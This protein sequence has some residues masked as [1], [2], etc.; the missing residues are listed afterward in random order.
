MP[1]GKEDAMSV[2]KV[3]ELLAES[4]KSWEDAA[5]DAVTEASKTIE[6]IQSVYVEN[7]QAIVEGAKIVKY[8]VNVKVCFLVKR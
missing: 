3:I 2:V 1:D 8:R 5:Q 7:F 6:N 4:S